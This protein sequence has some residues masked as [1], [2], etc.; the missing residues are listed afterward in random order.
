MDRHN[1]NE[2][3]EKMRK[4]ISKNIASII[5]FDFAKI[6]KTGI[7][8]RE[9]KE[10]Y[11]FIAQANEHDLKNF[12]FSTNK[13][14]KTERDK[15]C[16]KLALILSPDKYHLAS[17]EQ[18]QQL[19]HALSRIFAVKGKLDIEEQSVRDQQHFREIGKKMNNIGVINPKDDGF[20]LMNKLEHDIYITLIVNGSILSRQTHQALVYSYCKVLQYLILWS[21]ENKDG[22]LSSNMGLLSDHCV[23]LSK[24]IERAGA[25]EL[26][27]SILRV[28]VK[29][30]NTGLGLIGEQIE[31]D[32]QRKKVE[33]INK[34]INVIGTA[35]TIGVTGAFLLSGPGGWFLLSA[36][37]VSAAATASQAYVT[38][39]RGEIK[40]KD[41]QQM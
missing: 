6:Q 20:T 9:V 35:L 7:P 12:L 8:S 23:R 5:Q 28:N 14:D 22:W 34:G 2:F 27:E 4:S 10:L 18:S 19:G 38:E 31:K 33:S 13:S 41:R 25:S 11:E 17:S 15:I 36:A 40:N 29:V 39:K 30:G 3:G 16:R 21:A 24:N 1:S 26:F 32:K 37:T